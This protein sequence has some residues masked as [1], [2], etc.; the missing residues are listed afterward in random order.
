MLSAEPNSATPCAPLHPW[1]E[2]AQET[3]IHTAA[4]VDGVLTAVRGA[5]AAA[6]YS[7]RALLEVGLALE[8]ALVNALKHGNRGDA[9][10][11]VCVQWEVSA[12]RALLAVEDQGHGFDPAGV[13]DPLAPENRRKPSG[14][15]VLL[16]RHCLSWVRF[17]ERGNRVTLCK[18]RTD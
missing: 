5:L 12:R 6:G 14:R 17:N 4:E 11:H 16:M 3:R 15:G 8:E 1:G 7:E 13:P 9:R 10:K 18:L 2:R